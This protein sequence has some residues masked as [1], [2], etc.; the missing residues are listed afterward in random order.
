MAKT[1]YSAWAGQVLLSQV[2]FGQDKDGPLS[3]RVH[4]A[5][6]VCYNAPLCIHT[7]IWT[8]SKRVSPR[9]DHLFSHFN[10]YWFEYCK[11][12]HMHILP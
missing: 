7:A 10:M 2:H 6:Q 5:N 3:L 12:K 4:L 9:R 11:W 8:T 1:S